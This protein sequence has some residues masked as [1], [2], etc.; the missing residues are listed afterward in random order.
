MF[1]GILDYSHRFL[2]SSVTATLFTTFATRARQLRLRIQ[3]ITADEGEREMRTEAFCSPISAGLSE[4]MAR[5]KRR[6][7]LAL[8]WRWHSNVRCTSVFMP[9][10]SSR[11][12]GHHP[13]WDTICCCPTRAVLGAEGSSLAALYSQLC[14][15]KLSHRET[16]LGTTPGWMLDFIHRTFQSGQTNGLRVACH[17][18]G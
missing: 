13:S 1:R 7:A 18:M 5:R 17:P 11:C 3:R 16:T 8:R 10:P 2:R 15:V 4:S 14:M 9:S 6:G 12:R